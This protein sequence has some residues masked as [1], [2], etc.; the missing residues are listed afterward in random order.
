[1]K[2]GIGKRQAFW[3][4]NPELR[5]LYSVAVGLLMTSPRAQK[6][7]WRA[8]VKT[9]K[10]IK[11]SPGILMHGFRVVPAFVVTPRHLRGSW[12]LFK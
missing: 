1:M 11:S 6:P 10:R 3:K 5:P 9:M 12:R 4:H 2:T 7:T 8:V